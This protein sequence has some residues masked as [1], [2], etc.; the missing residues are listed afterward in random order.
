ME[1]TLE[2]SINGEIKQISGNYTKLT[3]EPGFIYEL[4]V[5]RNDV[6]ITVDNDN[7]IL[8]FPNG[9]V[10]V[11]QGYVDLV[12][13]GGPGKEP[14]VKFVGGE[15]IDSV[16]SQLDLLKIEEKTTTAVRNE[17]IVRTGDLV[18]DDSKD[19]SSS[20]T[21]DS[22]FVD[23]QAP[24]VTLTLS[25]SEL[26]LGETATVTFKFSETPSGFTSDDITAGNGYISNLKVDPNDSTKYTATFT[27]DANVADDTNIIK[28]GKDWAD[29]SGN[30]P[31]SESSS[32]NYTVDTQAL[33]A[34]TVDLN[35]SS[36][37]GSS[38]SDEI[39]NDDTP[40]VTVFLGDGSKAGD[41]V[42]LLQEGQSFST[43]ILYTLTDVDVVA[44]KI[45]LTADMLGSDGEKRLNA[46]ITGSAGDSATGSDLILVLDKT[47][48]SF[49]D[50]SGNFLINDPDTP[51]DISTDDI[52]ELFNSSENMT[53]L[54]RLVD[55][56][57][58]D[59]IAFEESM[60]DVEGH[61]IKWD[62]GHAV[63]A[64]KFQW[65]QDIGDDYSDFQGN[66]VSG[67]WRV[68][69]S[70]DDSNWVSLSD[71]ISLGM[72]NIDTFVLTKH[73]ATYRYYRILGVDGYASN[74]ISVQEAGFKISDVFDLVDESDSGSSYT[75]NI[76]SDTT[77]TLRV[78]LGGDAA[79]G[80]KYVF[81]NGTGEL[82]VHILSYADAAAKSFLFSVPEVAA[83][84]E[85]DHTFYTQIADL[86]GNQSEKRGLLT[87]TLDTHTP[88]GTITLDNSDLKPGETAAVTFK[89]SEKP[90]NFTDTDISAKNGV[91]SNLQV[92][93]Y[94]PTKYTATFTPDANVE[95]TSN[96]IKVGN[97]WQDVAGN[98]GSAISS[99][100]YKVD[101]VVSTIDSMT[102]NDT[103]PVITGKVGTSVTGS[104]VSLMVTVNGAVYENVSVGS[105]GKWRVDTG[106]SIPKAGTTLGN[107]GDGNS[108]EVTATVKDAA[109]ISGSDSTSNEITIDTT[110]PVIPTIDSLT[111]NGNTPVIT[112]KVGSSE[113]KIGESLFV[114]LNG[115]TYEN[116]TVG[117]DGKWRVDTG[118]AIPKPG[119]TLGSFADGNS[120][121]VTATVKDAAGNSSSDRTNNEITIDT[122]AP[123]YS[124]SKFIASTRVL[125]LIFNE[126]IE[127]KSGVILLNNITIK[128]GDDSGEVS[129]SD[130]E[131]IAVNPD[132]PTQLRIIFTSS[133]DL[134]IDFKVD[135]A[136]DTLQNRAGLPLDPQE[137]I[138]IEATLPVILNS[139]LKIN[140]G[141]TVTATENMINASDSN[142]TAD[143]LMFSVANVTNGRFELSSDPG[144]VVTKFT[145]DNIQNGDVTFVHDN[146]VFAPVF[147]PVFDIGINDGATA[148]APAPADDPVF[149]KVA[150]T[151]L[152][153]HWDAQNIDGDG[154]ETNQ[155][156][157]GATVTTW[158]DSS[159]SGKQ[160]NANQTV[161]GSQPTYA[162]T[163]INGH[164]ALKFDGTDDH[165]DISN[166][167]DLNT[168]TVY[169]QKT[170]ALVV[171]TGADV[172]GL[173][174]M[175]EGG[176]GVRGYSFGIQNG[177]IYAGIWNKREWDSGHRYK[178]VDLGEVNAN[179]TYVIT[180]VQDS[181]TGADDSNT[182]SIYLSG[183]LVAEVNHVD[184]QRVHGGQIAIGS[185]SGGTVA[186][187]DD[188]RFNG[189]GAYFDGYI[190]EL[191]LWNNALS[192]SEVTDLAKYMFNK[193]GITINPTVDL[194][195]R[196][197]EDFGFNA[198]G[199]KN[200]F[201]DVTDND[202]YVGDPDSGRFNNLVIKA[203]LLVDGSDEKLGYNGNQFS[204]ITGTQG[205]I[206]LI[207][208]TKIS[209]SVVDS[210]VTFKNNSG[211]TL[212]TDDM[213]DLLHNIKYINTSSTATA[214]DR[215]FEFTAEDSDG[216]VSDTSTATVSLSGYVYGDATANTLTGTDGSD[217]L[218][219]QLDNDTLTGGGGRDTFVYNGNDGN[220]IITDFSVT[221][222]AGGDILDLGDLLVGY[223]SGDSL[224]D[225]LQVTKSGSNTVISIDANGVEGGSS[226]TDVFTT[227]Q[228]VDTTLADLET[229]S[230]L[231]VM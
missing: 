23:K 169:A 204:L 184:I 61:W 155:P 16:T 91:I 126:S 110:V 196:N 37:S 212:T 80:D 117:N 29:G 109:G 20:T 226:Y 87:V 148:V 105:D 194:N 86:A 89:F 7:L 1:N 39:T 214:G 161:S 15:I 220:D 98:S 151:G 51:I 222:T 217:T 170:L 193:W 216:Q 22:P 10:I 129:A 231:L 90:S 211:G 131:S 167:K 45:E 96:F 135:I 182:L 19:N 82:G 229:N 53:S 67:T 78:K 223:D 60:P 32:A 59:G 12:L 97:E 219:G 130:I 141:E 137:N 188:Q 142:N 164:G 213:N 14:A 83:I 190:G 152:V 106:S 208:G 118:R 62:Y 133:V 54:G 203:E 156:A 44:G 3:V 209:Y 38:D 191:L 125:T 102:T 46:R 178:S 139:G 25:D 124:D 64:D 158:N 189:D 77:P 84:S 120:Y 17:D 27:P 224:G 65:E 121:E 162:A 52:T 75:D 123:T 119:T 8:T 143:Q 93:T 198:S 127:E 21:V 72:Y 5:P 175:Y 187:G 101:T 147:A 150:I 107:F 30:A 92:N 66:Y 13:A 24:N 49:Q 71:D 95:D 165:Y 195:G 185:V 56:D 230:N 128:Y 192:G 111:T 138:A 199:T 104:S 186:P 200:E 35:S 94:D 57:I 177:H 215:K 201:I 132:N 100:N 48:P 28:L 153:A 218:V 154:D 79:A 207:N 88:S 108:Y 227:L 180:V 36:D 171:Q 55:G 99:A 6:V 172:S 228:G 115:A 85:G 4:F 225:F 11:L 136:E 166:H 42:E 47:A 33:V 50:D 168:R 176:G 122:S 73:L 157:N 174:V 26:K 206:D 173:Q 205:S 43:A 31:E 134:T 116:I 181:S 81:Y 70:N 114:T 145:L 160:H 9:V 41:R 112:G 34:P 40:S 144:V 2:I 63:Y 221:G 179:A 18:A 58:S 74:N 202:S 159:G 140:Q 76:T 68:Q 113:L 149:G 210:S 69:G 197:S 146:S 103:T 183:L 163:A